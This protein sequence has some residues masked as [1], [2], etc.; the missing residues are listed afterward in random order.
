MF[1]PRRLALGISSLVIAAA[2]VGCSAQPGADGGGGGGGGDASASPAATKASFTADAPGPATL[3]SGRYKVSWSLGKECKKIDFTISSAD[4]AFT[5]SKSSTLPAFSAIVTVKAG[6]A[7]ALS[8]AA[9]QKETAC[10]SWK[11]NL[12]RIGA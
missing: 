7:T 12:D 2:A 9:Q 4:G 1:I 6:E 11:L 10:K 8:V 5:Y 3:Q